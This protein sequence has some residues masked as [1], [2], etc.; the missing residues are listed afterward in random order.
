MGSGVLWLDDDSLICWEIPRLCRGGSLSFT[1]PGVGKSWGFVVSNG[2]LTPTPLP[3]FPL[4]GER[5]E[6]RRG[7]R[8]SWRWRSG[9]FEGP[10]TG[11][12]PALPEDDYSL[13]LRG[14]LDLVDDQDFHWPLGR[15][16]FQ[17]KL[18]LNGSEN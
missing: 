16:K 7:D 18:F 17:A 11:K 8:V 15:F 9:P 14:P 12:P 5:E 2:P 13:V 4:P 3:L 1:V 10:A 6:G